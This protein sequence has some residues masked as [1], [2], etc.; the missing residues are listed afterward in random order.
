MAL[1]FDVRQRTRKPS[2]RWQHSAPT[3][4][5]ATPGSTEPLVLAVRPAVLGSSGRWTTSG[6]GWGTLQF[7][8]HR[9]SIDR[10]QTAWFSQLA[11]LRPSTPPGYAQD[12]DRILLDD[13]E[14]PLLWN[15]LAD[16]GAAGVELVT[17]KANGVVR[18][19]G[20]GSIS[21]DATRTTDGG[22]RLSTAA[23]IDGHVHPVD[24]VG[25]IADHGLYAV[26]WEGSPSSPPSIVLAPVAGGLTIEQQRLLDR[27]SI[28]I[29]AAG[30][31]EFFSDAYPRLRQTVRIASP[32]GSVAFPAIAP[33]ALTL[34]VQHRAGQ[35]VELSWE[36]VYRTGRATSRRPVGTPGGAE[37][38]HDEGAE[39][40]VLATAA[41]VVPGPLV[42]GTPDTLRGLDAA[43]FTEHVL[44]ELLRLRELTVEER[45]HRPDYRELDGVPELTI[46]AKES[47][48][49]DW[50]DLGVVV[51]VEGRTIPFTPL[52]RALSRG[53]K[54][55]LLVDNSYLTLDRPVFQSLR[56]LIDD[57]ATFPEWET[58]ELRLS[59][60]QAAA[61]SEFEELADETEQDPR[62]RTAVEGL[63]AFAAQDGSGTPEVV[64][65]VPLPPVQATLRPYQETGYRWL[66][67]LWSQRLG[68]IL[69][70]D[71][72]LGKTLQTLALIARAKEEAEAAGTALAAPF[73]V[74]APASVV[75]NWV[76]EAARF[77][78][79]LS[80][81][82]VSGREKAGR[83][84]ATA[85]AGA[86][87]VVVSYAVFRLDFDRFRALRWSGLILDEAQFVK[88]RT[89]RIHRCARDLD[90][91]FKLAITGT[92]LE[93]DLLELWALLAIVAPGLLPP[94]HRFALHYARP[95][96]AADEVA[97][98]RLATLR[99]RI[100]PLML[101]RT[102]DD[103]APELPEK[104]EQ[105]LSVE[106]APAHRRLYDAY[107]QRERQ[108]ILDLV[109]D[110]DRQRFNVLRSL[111]LLRRL[112]L[113]ASLIDTVDDEGRPHGEFA[114]VP[115][116]KI[117]AL[118]EQLDD[119][120]AEGHRA[121]VF[122]QFTTYL[123]KVSERLT[124]HGIDHVYLDG[125]T[126][127]RAEVIDGFR[128]GEAP[129]FLISLR[130]G[131]FGLNLVEADYVFLLDPWWN[132][133]V[134]NQAVDRAHRIGQTKRVMVYR[135]VAAGTIEEKV[136]E[137]KAKKSRLFDAVLDDGEMFDAAL[138]A[139]DIRELLDDGTARLPRARPRPPRDREA[140]ESAKS[141]ESAN[142]LNAGTEGTQEHTSR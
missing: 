121:L 127:R 6:I 29:P 21:L 55:L 3:T 51:T 27:R 54:K 7:H 111:T 11:A 60:S 88:N 13:Y 99:R 110:L 70:D 44:P 83:T 32:D 120:L 42:P 74:V 97:E 30:V 125:S 114:H 69:A 134:E 49:T 1:Q 28:S 31:A 71:M 43:A 59:R 93:N 37:T 64:R 18:V 19:A 137:L 107:L 68:G 141:A 140:A 63:L 48:R 118:L 81:V 38:F 112:S 98:R 101:R 80:V 138:T 124:E 53:A 36:W 89:S 46:T 108:K 86:D 122:S 47:E 39:A 119:V 12:R 66:H 9:L 76:S 117:D 20:D 142:T 96:E 25:R 109:D 131:G 62:W 133:A 106:L 73:L 91:P 58:G 41:A 56:E 16:A 14:S 139:D 50:F 4:V 22:L 2:E 136:M 8:V 87:M 116:S 115:S 104:Q 128:D 23:T 72:G 26:E 75:S 113:D 78:P 40:E 52:F 105:T 135:L 82:T 24:R 65:A 130:A 45:G 10:R 126:R 79:Q 67:F 61:W 5:T 103:V 57:A 92:P 85:A 33:P 84:L 90:A 34:V 132:P 77:A 102:K 95:I 123:A 35:S 15:L 17:S 100:R 129:V 94:V